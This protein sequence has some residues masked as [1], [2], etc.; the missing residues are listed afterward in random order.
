MPDGP[1]PSWL[2]MMPMV[3]LKPR[4]VPREPHPA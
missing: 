1:M 2:T 3:L 4:G